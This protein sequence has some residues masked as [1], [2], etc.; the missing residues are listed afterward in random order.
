MPS[1]TLQQQKGNSC[2]AHCMVVAISEISDMHQNVLDW[3]YAQNTVW[4]AIQFV[5]TGGL[6]QAID[7]L[8]KAQNSDPRKIVIE[9]EKITNKAVKTEL[10]CDDSQKTNALGYVTDLLTK[11]GLGALFNLIK[12]GGTSA[13][14]TLTEG[15]FYNASYLMF[16]GGNAATGSFVGMHNILVTRE[17]GKDYYYNPNESKPCW[18]Q[19]SDWKVLDNQNSGNH[20]YV[21]TGVCVE[22][23]K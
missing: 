15:I 16:K 12:G 17:G 18:S 8:A 14:L 20:S 6:S 11:Q 22:M 5:S 10:V 3:S 2:A 7:D 4:P 9:T 1:K 21:F 13:N 23:K 19:T